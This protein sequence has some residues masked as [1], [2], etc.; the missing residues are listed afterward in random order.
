[1]EGPLR[2][3]GEYYADECP[4]DLPF[5]RLPDGADHLI[6]LGDLAGTGTLV[7]DG[8]TGALLTWT[9]PETTPQPLTADVSTL[10]FTL[11][12]RS[13]ERTT[14]HSPVAGRDALLEAVAG[15]QPA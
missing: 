6:R 2:T 8:T 10:A 12:L 3:L 13:R 15:I 11:W 14:D 5:D 9:D 7:A 4:G 1:V